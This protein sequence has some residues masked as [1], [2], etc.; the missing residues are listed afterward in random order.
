MIEAMVT[1]LSTSAFKPISCATWRNCFT[2]IAIISSELWV[3]VNSYV[4]GNRYPSRLLAWGARSAIRAVSVSMIFRKSS[5][6][7]EQRVPLR[8]HHHVHIDI[9]PCQ[10]VVDLD[11]VRCP[12]EQ[13][14]SR[15]QR[16]FTMKVMPQHKRIDA[17]NHARRFQFRG[18]PSRGVAGVQQDEF[19]PRRRHRR[20]ERPS[21]PAARPHGGQKHQYQESTHRLPI[22]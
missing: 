19:L 9:T 13:I 14:L 11:R 10:A 21:Q 17:A 12:L 4:L 22:V 6:D 2:I 7:P 1:V 8:D 16:T 20:P 15:F 18:N 5:R 3:R